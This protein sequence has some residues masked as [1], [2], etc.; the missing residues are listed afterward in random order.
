MREEQTSELEVQRKEAA[1]ASITPSPSAR[2]VAPAALAAAAEPAMSVVAAVVP[3]AAL[4]IDPAAV[5][6]Q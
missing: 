2:N 4:R 1:V 5:S 6:L 3:P